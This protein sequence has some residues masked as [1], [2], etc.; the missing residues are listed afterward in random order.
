MR[1]KRA[2]RI[3]SRSVWQAPGW[4]FSVF[5]SLSSKFGAIF[6]SPSSVKERSTGNFCSLLSTTFIKQTT[7]PDR[8][9]Q[10]S[11]PNLTSSTRPKSFAGRKIRNKLNLLHVLKQFRGRW[12]LVLKIKRIIFF[13]FCPTFRCKVCFKFIAHAVLL[14]TG[15]R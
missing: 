1:V 3:K 5:P 6:W 15:W 2:I 13:Y 9:L 8:D 14:S 7:C 4:L 11:H 10:P 12:S